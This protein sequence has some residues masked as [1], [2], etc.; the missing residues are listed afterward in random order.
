MFIRFTHWLKD[1]KTEAILLT[2]IL[3]ISLVIRLYRIDEYLT[4]LGD[5]G[6]D[7]RI[8]RDLLKGNFVFIGPQTSIGNMYLGPLYYYMMAPALFLSHLNPVG[9][10][11]MTAILATVTIGFTFFVTR[12]WFGSVAALFATILFSLSPV[13][14]IYSRTSWNPNPMPFFALLCVWGIYQV[15]DKHQFR[16][17]PI[18]GASLAFALQMH[19]LGLLLIP[20]ILLFWYLSIR[21]STQKQRKLLAIHSLIAIAIFII[22]MSPLVLFDIKH[23][24]LN[25]SAFKTFFTNRQTTVNLN[26]INSDRFFPSLSLFSQELILS[27]N[28][29]YSLLA[30]VIFLLLLFW[31]FRQ[32]SRIKRKPLVLCFVWLFFGLLGFRFLDFSVFITTI[33]KITN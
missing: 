3:L 27:R 12:N 7:V 28:Q 32:A 18:V 22:L 4:F 25:Y 10:A 6:R 26:P 17:L 24:G 21:T 31:L 2:L 30:A 19:Y 13:A 29:N 5:E 9:P 1:Y 8:V 23:Q 20:T 15:W 33:T 16:W 11:I 14:I